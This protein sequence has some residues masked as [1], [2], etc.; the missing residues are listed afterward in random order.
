MSIYLIFSEIILMEKNSI[1]WKIVKE[2]GT[3]LCSKSLNKQTNKQKKK[4]KDVGIMKSPEK[5]A[6][7]SGTTGE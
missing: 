4:N 1:L 3:V 5:T 7:G 2:P 6:G